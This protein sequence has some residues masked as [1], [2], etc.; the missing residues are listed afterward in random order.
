M[1]STEHWLVHEHTQF[2]E[3]LRQ[4]KGAADIS[5]WWALEQFFLK[6]VESLR[7]HMAQE[8]EVL[9]PAYEAKCESS[10]MSTSELRNE[11]SVMI[12]SFRELVRYINSRQ[13]KDAYDCIVALELFMLGHNEKEELVF[14]PYASRLLYEDRDELLLKLDKFVVSKKSRNWNLPD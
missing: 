11:H 10:S 8:E 6:L 5:D 7:F 13:S 2:E 14:L 3:L 12:E 1:R 9:F 4:C